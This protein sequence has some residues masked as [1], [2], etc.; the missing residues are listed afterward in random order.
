MIHKHN[1]N[2]ELR[3]VSATICHDYRRDTLQEKNTSETLEEMG[4]HW[5]ANEV[6]RARAVTWAAGLRAC[7]WG[8]QEL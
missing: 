5:S 6:Q 7:K 4:L 1:S 2:W 8:F 3:K